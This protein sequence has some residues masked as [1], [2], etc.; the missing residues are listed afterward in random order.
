MGQSCICSSVCESLK[1]QF[2]QLHY[3][4]HTTLTIHN[5]NKI[6]LL[7]DN[8]TGWTNLEISIHCMH[9]PCAWTNSTLHSLTQQWPSQPQISLY[10][11]DCLTHSG[12]CMVQLIFYWFR[13][14]KTCLFGS[15]Q[16]SIHQQLEC[17][18]PAYPDPNHLPCLTWCSQTLIFKTGLEGWT[19]DS[20]LNC[21]SQCKH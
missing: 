9:A 16:Q 10:L 20:T 7:C 8:S 17:R 15:L 21:W 14:W 2:L 13:N 11:H 3:L 6:I 12:A 5:N 18:S 1:L 4:K 19:L